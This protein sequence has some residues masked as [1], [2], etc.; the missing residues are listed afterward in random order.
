MD[1]NWT[2]TEGIM[3]YAFRLIFVRKFLFL[4]GC[5]MRIGFI[6]A[7]VMGKTMGLLL[8]SCGYEIVGYTSRS[9]T[10]AL[11]V[12]KEVGGKFFSDGAKLSANS[13]ILFLT[14]PDDVIQQVCRVLAKEE[15]FHPRQVVAHMS[16][17]H[18]SAI[19]EPAER[20][21]AFPLSMHPFQSCPTAEKALE[22]LPRSVF[23]LEGSPEAVKI[24]K[25][26]V[27]RMGADYFVLDREDKVLY[28]A[29]ACMASNYLVALMGGAIELLRMSGV[30]EEMLL[31]VLLPLVEGTLD[32]LKELSPAA[33]LTGPI[34]RGD[35]NT[36][37]RHIESIEEKAPELL[38]M[39]KALGRRTL[40]LAMQKQGF[41]RAKLRTLMALLR[42]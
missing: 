39:Y 21:G 8:G 28:H 36:V 26:M 25:A 5:F 30:E 11:R 12:A 31:P 1:P 14:T 33:A 29:A 3:H 4:E 2:E 13:D 16:G 20:L 9:E 38:D 37:E 42:P 18:T 7:G 23:S 15:G 19:L 35:I 17:S 32:N 34:K 40:S 24:G 22:N 27:S 10:S 41:D 6:G